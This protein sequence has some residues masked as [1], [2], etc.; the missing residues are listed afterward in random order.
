MSGAP[1]TADGLSPSP[2]RRLLAALEGGRSGTLSV[3]PLYM[4]LYLAKPRHEAYARLWREK[5][6]AAGGSVEVTYEDYLAVERE[7]WLEGYRLFA[8]APDWLHTPTVSGRGVEG[9]TVEVTEEGCFWVEASGERTQLD[10]PFSSMSAPLWEASA[11]PRSVADVEARMPLSSPEALDA[12]LKLA[13]R[14]VEELCEEYALHAHISAPYPAAY[15]QL[16]FQGLMLAIRERPELVT[17][18]AERRLAG[19]IAHGAAARR[20]GLEVMFIEEWACGADLVSPDDYLNFAWPFERDL[21]RALKQMGFRV[22]LYFC[23]SIQDRLQHLARLEADA[24]ALEESK[25]G[26]TV[27]IGDVR[28]QVGEGRCLLGNIDVVLLRDGGRDDIAAEVERQVR[29]AGPAAF[30]TS[31]GSPVTLDTPPGKVDLLMEAARGT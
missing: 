3:A 23:G 11:P 16:G 13:S 17:A 25:K 28:R 9:A 26:W 7:T 1:L 29:A 15:A 14:L 2:K 5:A 21:C 24:L 18:I 30:V 22:V 8:H 27:D 31:V 4:S 12:N 10:R 20:A 19:C 6:E